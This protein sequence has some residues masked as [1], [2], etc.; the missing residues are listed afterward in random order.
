MTIILLSYLILLYRRPND[1]VR[2]ACCTA[3][4]KPLRAAV[5]LFRTYH[6]V[7]DDSTLYNWLYWGSLTRPSTCLTPVYIGDTLAL[8]NPSCLPS[9]VL[10]NDYDKPADI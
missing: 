9:Q 5:D 2:S 7:K 8:A 10:H 4:Y 3:G 6:I 1:R